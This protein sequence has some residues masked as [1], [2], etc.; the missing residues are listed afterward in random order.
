ME[1]NY[2]FFYAKE[3]GRTSLFS[4][5]FSGDTPLALPSP[6]Q[7]CFG[8]RAEL[9][10][11][12]PPR[13]FALGFAR[14]FNL[15]SPKHVNDSV[16]KSKFDNLYGCRESLADGIKR[17]TDVMIAGK[18]A[19]VAGYGDV[20][21]GSAHSLRGFGARVIVTEIDPINA[22]QAA[23]EGFEATTLEDTLGIGDIYMTTTGN[24]DVITLDHI[25]KMKDQAI[26]CNI[27]H[28]DNEIQVDKLNTLKGVKKI[29]V[30]PQYDKYVLPNGRTIYLLA[31]G[32]LVNLGCATGHPS[33]VI[34]NSFTNQCLAQIDQAGNRDGSRLRAV[35]LGSNL[36]PMT[37][38]PQRGE[39]AEF[40]GGAF[41]PDLQNGK[42]SGILRLTPGGVDFESDQGIFSLPLEGLSLALGGANDRLIFFT[43]P[44][45]PQVTIHT[46]DH[47]VLNHPVLAAHPEL[48]AQVGRV[49]NKKRLA[50]TVLLS[51]IG[52][53][54]ASLVGLILAKDV[55]VNS[56]ASAIPTD[57]EVKLGDKLFQQLMVSRREIKDPALEAQLAKITGPLVA[58]IKDSRYPLKFHIIE[59]PT[60]NAFAVPGGNVVVHSGLLLAADRPEEVAGVLAHEIAH[61]TKRHGFR[62]IISSL[63][64]YQVLQAFVG[65]ATGLLAVLAN[66]SAF[67]MDR[68][69]SRD[70]EREADSAGWEY[71]LGANIE[72][73]GMIEFF[74]KLRME[75]KKQLEQLHVEGAEKALSFV[76]THP[77]TE[78]RVRTLEERLKKLPAKSGFHKFDLNYTGFKDS[79][80]A[81]LHSAPEQKETN[82]SIH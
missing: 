14:T 62:S 35:L 1:K 3:R 45:H 42:A 15:F 77:G 21:K 51:V 40:D 26:V 65:D 70:F 29:N 75:E 30:K 28:F 6:E 44:I 9:F 52:L 32:R 37:R 10:L 24:C 80:R 50:W 71:L 53:L 59:D 69:F 2:R 16:T 47:S 49:R 38:E 56:L 74:K 81:R 18:V 68:K 36:A 63:G 48:V 61:V 4:S 58:G 5:S 13:R 12:E 79:L 8:H 23:M 57:W 39:R 34:S 78:E 17:A 31:E 41:H 55:I 22:L 67:L 7:V 73:D 25:L 66:N 60:L 64:L 76:S 11:I 19:V 27:G 43:H 46:A 82:E 33:F 54:V 72:P 20:G